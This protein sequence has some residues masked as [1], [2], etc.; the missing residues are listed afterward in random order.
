MNKLIREIK[1]ICIA[2]IAATTIGLALNSSYA[3]PGSSKGFA[4]FTEDEA[5]NIAA[6]ENEINSTVTESNDNY[7]KSLSIDNGSLSPTFYRGITDYTVDISDIVDKTTLSS[8]TI[9]AVTEDDGATIQGSGKV[10]LN[11]GDNTIKIIVTAKDKSTRTYTIKVNR[12]KVEN[13]NTVNEVTTSNT[14]ATNTTN[15]LSNDTNT[16]LANTTNTTA[17]GFFNKINFKSAPMIILAVIILLIIILIIL[18]IINGKQQHSSKK[19]KKSTEDKDDFYTKMKQG[20][21]DYTNED[22]DVNGNPKQEKSNEITDIYSKNNELEDENEETSKEEK[23]LEKNSN[24]SQEYYKNDDID[25]NKYNEQKEE[26][27][28]D[29]EEENERNN[30]DDKNN[31]R[32]KGKHF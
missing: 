9:S 12:P 25:Y 17:T 1:I 10:N 21:T 32:Y 30:K 3:D 4:D 5:A 22:T 11:Y 8:L 31:G 14:V 16:M 6:Q 28:T 2:I 24:I 27:K 7:L 15:T 13:N 29:D 19:N 20:Y 18:L 23:D 26:S